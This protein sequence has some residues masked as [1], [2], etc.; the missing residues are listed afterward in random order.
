MV[1]RRPLSHA[2]EVIVSVDG[3]IE[4]GE[5]VE[6]ATRSI[7]ITGRVD[8]SNSSRHVLKR[9]SNGNLLEVYGEYYTNVRAPEEALKSPVLHI[10]GL[11]IY[12]P[13]IAW[14]NYQTHSVIYV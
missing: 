11:G 9:D 13:I 12:R 7:P 10:P 5:W 4:N 3:R 6:G 1:A 2:A 14:E 8:H